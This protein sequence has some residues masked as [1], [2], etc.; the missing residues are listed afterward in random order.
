MVEKVSKKKVI[1]KT[2]VS[3][4]KTKKVVKKKVVASPSVKKTEPIG[5]DEI[6]TE[7]AN[8]FES[9]LE[10]AAGVSSRKDKVVELL[11]STD[12]SE[13]V[14][15]VPKPSTEVI[16]KL[17]P[18]I[19]LYMAEW[20]ADYPG[21]MAEDYLTDVVGLTY[22]ETAQLFL[23]V[24]KWQW[25]QKKDQFADEVVRRI[26]LRGANRIATEYDKDIQFSKLAKEKLMKIMSEGIEETLPDGVK[27]TTEPTISEIRSIVQ[28]YGSTQ[29]IADKALGISDGNREAILSSLKKE[30]VEETTETTEVKEIKQISYTEAKDMVAAIREARMLNEEKTGNTEEGLPEEETGDRAT[31]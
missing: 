16:E 15:V 8:T 22:K 1:K 21:L 18:M 7:E 20:C 19:K 27:K 31:A 23:V 11:Y 25:N 28:S 3:K 14:G 4:K 13:I 10:N 9:L 12:T 2:K 30:Q 29:N 5:V 6:P 26:I 17:K 24:P